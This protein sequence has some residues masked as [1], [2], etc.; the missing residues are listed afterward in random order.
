ME[1]KLIYLIDIDSTICKTIDNDYFHSE[2]IQEVIDEVN[3]LYD[4][5]YT[6]KIFTGRGSKSGTN[7]K[8]LIE[9]QLKEWRVKYHELIMGKPDCSS[10]I[11][12]KAVDFV[13]WKYG[14]GKRIDELSEIIATCERNGKKVLICGNGG[15][16]AE[17][18]HFKTEL[19]GKYAFDVYIPCIALDGNTAIANDMGF[20]NVFAHQVKV[21]GN[22]DDIFIGMTT[23]HS[24]NII[25]ALEEANKKGLTT[26]AICST[27][28][29]EFEADYIVDIEGKDTAE[30]QENILKF[31][32][33]LAYK[34]K[35]KVVEQ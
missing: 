2:P 25:R 22:I 32:H 8:G 19:I 28:Y 13:K 7:W 6:I 27:K 35:E 24:E 21:L 3:R 9:Y 30:I 15:L 33:K 16:D 26:V 20:E 1:T 4:K 29:K 5:G 14:F 12:D 10:I 11:D 18:L 34:A 17:S 23:S 31:L